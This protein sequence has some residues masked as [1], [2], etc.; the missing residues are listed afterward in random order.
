MINKTQGEVR[1]SFYG[2][3]GLLLI[4]LISGLNHLIQLVNWYLLGRSN[5]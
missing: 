3:V 4:H 2:Y 5:G 1:M